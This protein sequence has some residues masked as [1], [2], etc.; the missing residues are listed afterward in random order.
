MNQDNDLLNMYADP[1]TRW[2]D[3]MHGKIVLITGANSGIGFVTARELAKMGAQVLM[4]CRNAERGAQAQTEVAMEATGPVP[5]LLLAD[6]SSQAEVRAL[7]TEIGR[8][9]HSIDVLINN[10][11]AIFARRELTAD[12][13]ERT[14][15]T[16]FLGPFLLTNL[17]LDLVRT[18]GGRIINVASESYPPKLDF[19]NLQGEK[20][21]SFLNAYFRSKLENII[22]SMDLAKQLQDSGV[23][24]NCFSPGPTNTGFGDGMSGLA[25]LF[26]RLAKKLFP[27]REKGARTLI[28][29]ASSPEVAD[30]SGR[31]FLRQR[32]RRTKPVTH[33]A[34]IAARLWH[35]SAELVGLRVEQPK[36]STSAK[37]V[38]RSVA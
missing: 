8:R 2:D 23:T 31:F 6:M 14:F 32:I 13:I 22:F 37:A 33:D 30:V 28:Y 35:L 36:P 38:S 9:F 34:E 21:Y 24:V 27:S 17:V 1:L 18:G 29:L 20:R 10:A 3:A 26:P 15:A 25:G 11:G 7:A 12:G 16:N 19:G 4:V 5:E